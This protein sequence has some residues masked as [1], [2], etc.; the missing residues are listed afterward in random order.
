MSTRPP[1]AMPRAA[2]RV[3][4]WFLPPAVQRDPEETRR[5]RLVVGSAL[6]LSLGAMLVLLLADWRG[7]VAIGGVT[8]PKP[9]VAAILL[10]I[11]VNLS[12]ALLV[13]VTGSTARAA[14]LLPLS[15]VLFVTFLTLYGGG[16]H[17]PIT[18]W[19]LAV[20]LF[21][22]FLGGAR[23]ALVAAVLSTAVLAGLY[24]LERQ[25]MRYPNTMPST[26]S[27][28]GQLRSQV[29][30]LAF[31]T[32]IGWFYED[33]RRRRTDRLTRAHADLELALSA[34]Q[35]SQS[36]LVQITE[37]IGQAIWMERPADRTILYANR[38]FAELWG[39]PLEELTAA[40]DRWKHQVV[41]EDRGEI[42]D[43]HDDREHVY[44]IRTPAGDSRWIRHAVFRVGGGDPATARDV[45]IAANIT[46]KR[47]A[48]QLREQFID[49]VIRAQETER[50]HLAR[51]LHDGTS[52]SLAALLVG[53]KMLQDQI[54]EPVHQAH[55]AEL[56]EA[57]RTV[58]DD[59]RRTSRGL[60][61]AV[62]DAHG[63]YAAVRRLADDTRES[64]GLRVAVHLDGEDMEA[65][66]PSA[67]R[68]TAWRILQEALGNVL[69]HAG[70]LHVDLTVSTGEDGVHLRVED[71]GRGFDPA[72]V[73][74]PTTGG[75]LGLL[76]MRE[77]AA[78]LGGEVV[79]ES[80]HGQ[81][82]TVICDLPVRAPTE[83]VVA[84]PP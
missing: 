45:H 62:L 73:R 23:S 84:L 65:A 64:T 68:L 33:I 26:E 3:I 51:E 35:L 43:A 39:V 5:A 42:P 75:G 67:V 28:E 56:R 41:T 37:N 31:V 58:V 1:I 60:H 77:R 21:G 83:H 12:I 2:S 24:T 44:R 19:I 7:G 63:L 32:W 17:S 18:W 22:A 69:K 59:L 78:L 9:A 4:R 10:M 27:P 13:R 30:L 82:A 48:E 55:V 79:V 47:Q 72:Q 14:L 71:D 52:Q 54:A 6:V 53:M 40:P 57:L 46:L 70:A 34:L 61:P 66:L 11:P 16:F 25:G 49:A 50:K 20:P 81:G 8:L 36:Q 76:S 38:P 15:L 29:M 80:A 74:A